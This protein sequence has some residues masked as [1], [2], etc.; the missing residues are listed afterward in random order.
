MIKED[1]W[2]QNRMNSIS[3]QRKKLGDRIKTTQ[4]EIDNL[5]KER[6]MLQDML[7]L[8]EKYD[9]EFVERK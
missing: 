8:K 1:I 6:K 5:A 3:K 7:D 9:K 2:I 4:L